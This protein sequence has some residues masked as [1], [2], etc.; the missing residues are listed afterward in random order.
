VDTLLQIGLSNA[1][2][3]TLLA[4]V[5]A[6]A[7]RF[8]RRPALIHALW[9]LVLLKLVI[10]SPLTL[11]ISWSVAAEAVADGMGTDG[12]LQ[13]SA[14]RVSADGQPGA[15]WFEAVRRL[16]SSAATWL[17]RF[18]APLI[19]TLWLLGSA[20]WFTLA[21]IRSYR[22]ARLLRYGRP[23]P[24]ALQEQAQHLAEDLGLSQCPSV[25]LV[26]GTLSP[27]LWG[28]GR[29][30]RL[31]LP[32]ELVGRLDPEQLRT[33]LVHEL[34]HA[35]RRDPW[36]RLLELFVLGLYWWHPVAW[37][38]RRRLREAEE[39]C[40]DAWVVWALPA[41]AASYATALVETVAFLS[42]ARPALPPV[43]SGIG[44]VH[45][46]KQRLILILRGAPPK[47]VTLRGLGAVVG[48]GLVLLPWRPVWGVDESSV[49]QPPPLEPAAAVPATEQ[50]PVDHGR[51][52]VAV[53]AQEKAS[54]QKEIDREVIQERRP[55][56]GLGGWIGRDRLPWDGREWGPPM[57]G[58]NLNSPWPGPRNLFGGRTDFL[59]E[60]MGGRGR[61]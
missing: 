28:L 40:C 61:R 13:P 55:D 25:W 43:A 6:A 21:G 34:A 52:A 4:V 17:E 45:H 36:V 49:S 35:R 60:R 41:A 54:P 24:A 46:L 26:P 56:R 3:A 53:P 11:N 47:G 33:L 44:Y 57:R 20:L 19:L 23:A 22:F 38:A 9:L 42:S 2:V 16:T 10:P 48:L 37:W 39:Q 59:R 5:A 29:G 1:L 51:R 58:P 7:S 32:A 8:C 18:G 12:T 50:L 31:L 30:A 14:A 15:A 27:M